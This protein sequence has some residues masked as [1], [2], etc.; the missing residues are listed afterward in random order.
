[1]SLRA[2][3]TCISRLLSAVLLT[4]AT[5][6]IVMPSAWPQKT[7]DNTATTQSSGTQQQSTSPGS[8]SP[9]MVT[10]AVLAVRASQIQRYRQKAHSWYLAFILWAVLHYALGVISVASSAYVASLPSEPSLKTRKAGW[11]ITAA[12]M[13]GLITFLS[14]VEHMRAFDRASTLL[15]RA[16]NRFEEQPSSVSILDVLD[17]QT[18][19]EDQLDAAKGAP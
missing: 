17:A 19:A 5:S 4:V 18:K 15:N 16:C 9:V 12:V 2:R 3:S 13:T 8:M 11:A 1:M 7:P 14:P 10:P 6:A